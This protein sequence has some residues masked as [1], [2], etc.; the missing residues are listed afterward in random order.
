MIF[1][2]LSKYNIDNI[3]CIKDDLIQYFRRYCDSGRFNYT[4]I[5]YI[6]I[7]SLLSNMCSVIV[8]KRKIY[9]HIHIYIYIWVFNCYS[10]MG[11]H[12]T[13]MKK[14]IR[15][16]QLYNILLFCINNEYSFIFVPC[17]K[18]QEWESI[19][20]WLLNFELFI[21]LF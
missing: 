2:F 11:N 12:H 6:W 18:Y 14:I 10:F 9:M 7:Y 4:Y 16:S 15:Y 5:Q 21:C 17:N 20:K 8:N 3:N 13:I 1:F 19:R